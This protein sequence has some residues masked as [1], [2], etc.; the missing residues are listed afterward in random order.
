[1]SCF[2]PAG[3]DAALVLP[4]DLSEAADLTRPVLVAGGEPTA[5]VV[6]VEV[7]AQGVGD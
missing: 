7:E 2:A 6:L 5:V 4:A 1:M 3:T